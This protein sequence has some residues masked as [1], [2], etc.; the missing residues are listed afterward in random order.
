MT[1]GPPVLAALRERFV[2]DVRL[3][4]VEPLEKVDAFVAAGAD[5]ATFHIEATSD[6]HAV[7][8]RLDDQGVTRGVALK[9]GTPVSSIEPLL[10]D[11]DGAAARRPSRTVEQPVIPATIDRSSRPGS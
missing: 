6:P 7:L 10:D 8:E 5:I 9:P 3:V 11:L 4:I 2:I 1:V